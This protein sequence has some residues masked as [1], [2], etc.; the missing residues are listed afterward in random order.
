M[1]DVNFIVNIFLYLFRIILQYEFNFSLSRIMSSWSQF[2]ESANVIFAKNFL[3][4]WKHHMDSPS[5]QVTDARWLML[6]R[7]SVQRCLWI[8]LLLGNLKLQRMCR[9]ARC[10]H[11]YILM[12]EISV[13][14]HFNSFMTSSI[15]KCNNSPAFFTRIRIELSRTFIN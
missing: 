8:C 14:I 11:D 6:M 12:M 5:K 10:I 9:C 13:S 1:A 4:F 2:Y 7:A 15:L 3:L